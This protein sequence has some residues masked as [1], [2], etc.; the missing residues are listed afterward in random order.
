M[1]LS[2]EN[3]QQEKAFS[4]CTRRK[5]VPVVGIELICPH[6]VLNVLLPG[7][8]MVEFYGDFYLFRKKL[9]LQEL[10]NETKFKHIYIFVRHICRL[11]IVK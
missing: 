3:I 1:E 2:S 8:T 6:S 9:A 5:V 7:E 11:V 10:S 4:H